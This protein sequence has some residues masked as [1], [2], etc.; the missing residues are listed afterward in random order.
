MSNQFKMI[1]P[2]TA[3]RIKKKDYEKDA[4]G[5]PIKVDA[6]GHTMEPDY[7]DIIDEDIL[8]EWKN[9]FGS[10]AIKAAAEQAVEPAVIRMWYIS[11]ITPDC[12]IMRVEDEAI[13]EII[14]TPDDVMN[15]HQQLEIQ[16]KRYREGG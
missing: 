12:K 1:R 14:G 6:N 4:Q 5:N 10:E 13:F 2:D 9:K 7:R 3:I 15:R 16:V 8:C 11:G